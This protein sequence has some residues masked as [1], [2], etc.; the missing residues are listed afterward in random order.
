[1]K[2]FKQIVILEDHPGDVMEG[3]SVGVRLKVW[4]TS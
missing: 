1:M 4:E 2:C 3:G